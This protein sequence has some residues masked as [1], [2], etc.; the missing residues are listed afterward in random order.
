MPLVVLRL[1]VFLLS[2]VGLVSHRDVYFS[3]NMVLPCYSPRLR[4]L[5][6]AD[7]RAPH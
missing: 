1:A 5:Y 6:C 7:K 4:C 2:H 3:K